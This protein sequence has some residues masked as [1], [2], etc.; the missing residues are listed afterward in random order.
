MLAMQIEM[1][2]LAG[3]AK[4]EPSP[5]LEQADVSND[6]GAAVG[7]PEFT[8]IKVKWLYDTIVPFNV[9]AQVYDVNKMGQD[10]EVPSTLN[11]TA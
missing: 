8:S 2:V 10:I 6:V 9:L 4:I 11:N 5:E 1:N 3:V 7:S